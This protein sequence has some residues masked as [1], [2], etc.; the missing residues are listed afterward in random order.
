MDR[1]TTIQAALTAAFAGLAIYFNALAVPLI[2]LIIIMICDYVS[3]MVKAYMTSQLS[4]KIG[5]K[6]IIKKLCY[7]ITVVVAMSV[8]YILSLGLSTININ[9]SNNTTVAMIVTIWLILNEMISVLENLAV[10]GAPLPKFLKTIVKKL[11]IT[12]DNE[13]EDK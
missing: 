5:I 6:G 13:S 1:Q 9:I 12:V 4:S 11:K 10:I 3:G 2:I 7:M 8:D